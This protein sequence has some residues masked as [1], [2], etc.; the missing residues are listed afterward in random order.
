MSL[1]DAYRHAQEAQREGRSLHTLSG[2]D[3]QVDMGDAWRDS[4]ELDEL[5]RRHE[6]QRE[7]EAG[8]SVSVEL[9]LLNAA[10]ACGEGC[11]REAA[12]ELDGMTFCVHCLG[13]LVNLGRAFVEAVD[14]AQTHLEALS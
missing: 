8:G 1:S 13:H 12:V 2:H 6:K 4:T 10:G 9:V 11:G 14:G 7:R 5:L 3:P